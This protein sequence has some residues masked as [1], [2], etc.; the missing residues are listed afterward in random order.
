M[1]NAVKT[2]IPKRD[3]RNGHQNISAAITSTL[4]FENKF[5]EYKNNNFIK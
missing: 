5:T 3:I 2:D 4:H 1:I